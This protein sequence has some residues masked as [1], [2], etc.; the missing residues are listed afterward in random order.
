M[1]HILVGG[2]GRQIERASDFTQPTVDIA[3]WDQVKLEFTFKKKEFS[4]FSTKKRVSTP[5]LIFVIGSHNCPY[6]VLGT[7]GETHVEGRRGA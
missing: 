3:H 6:S 5:P 7:V 4:T 2:P 1:N